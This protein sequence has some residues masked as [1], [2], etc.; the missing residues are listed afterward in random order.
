[1][2]RKNEISIYAAPARHVG[3]QNT[4]WR[5]ICGVDDAVT[6]MAVRGDDLCC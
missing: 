2:V 1:M 6:S 4:P 5:K 3:Q